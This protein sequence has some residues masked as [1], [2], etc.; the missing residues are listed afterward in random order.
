MSEWV[1]V[2]TDVVGGP[3]KRWRPQPTKQAALTQA[4]DM[5]RR[6]SVIIRIEGPETARVMPTAKHGLSR[7]ATSSE[8]SL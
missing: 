6:G 2:Y 5:Y 4:A 3:E 8:G 7:T 1:I